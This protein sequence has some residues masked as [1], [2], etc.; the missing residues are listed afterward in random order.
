MRVEITATDPID[1]EV[2]LASNRGK[3]KV[4]G[5]ATTKKTFSDDIKV[6]ANEEFD[7]KVSLAAGTKAADVTVKANSID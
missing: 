6:P 7:I 5:K 4:S 3:G 2:V 1:V